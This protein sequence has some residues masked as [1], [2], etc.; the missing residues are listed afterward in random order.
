MNIIHDYVYAT[1]NKTQCYK[2]S[3]ILKDPVKLED[4][5]HQKA[6]KMYWKTP[7]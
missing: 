7:L 2:P 5:F 6:E 3:D 4:P 1:Q